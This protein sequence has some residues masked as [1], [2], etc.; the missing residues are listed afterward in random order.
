MSDDFD[1]IVDFFTSGCVL[2]AK[3]VEDNAAVDIDIFWERV[4]LECIFCV[5]DW[6]RCVFLLLFGFL[7]EESLVIFKIL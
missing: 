2:L 4:V 6:W 3:G 1:E 5:D 7:S